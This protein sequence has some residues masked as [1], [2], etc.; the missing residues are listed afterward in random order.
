MKVCGESDDD[1]TAMWGG[2]GHDEAHAVGH[3]KKHDYCVQVT[4][5]KVES[6]KHWREHGDKW[7]KKHHVTIE[8]GACGA[9]WSKEVHHRD[10]GKTH[11]KIFMH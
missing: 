11:W 3:Y 9:T 7:A 2:A 10:D 4:S 5:P 1:I 6:D 8:D